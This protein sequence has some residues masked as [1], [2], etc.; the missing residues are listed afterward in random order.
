MRSDPAY[1]K[2]TAD[3]FLAMDFGTDK[4][5][6]LEDGVIVMMAGGTE[7]HAWVQGNILTWLRPR[8]KGTGCRPYGPDM[9]VRVSDTDVRYPDVSIYCDQPP[10]E[11]LTEATT[12]RDPAVVIEVLSPSTT[13]LDQGGKLEE[14]KMLPTVRTIAFVDPVNQMCRTIERQSTGGWLDHIFSGTSGI[15][16]PSLNLVIPHDEIFA[17]D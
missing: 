4:R 16:I 13:M 11:E 7:P 17:G 9:A 1:R 6:E 5:F 8:L 14:Y 2:I 12:L 10:R 15:A 3:E